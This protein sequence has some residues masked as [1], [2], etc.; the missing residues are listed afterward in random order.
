MS[1]QCSRQQSLVHYF[2][3]LVLSLSLLQTAL[4]SALPNNAAAVAAATPASNNANA[5]AA[6]ANAK[7]EASAVSGSAVANAQAVAASNSA[8]ALG[9]AAVPSMNFNGTYHIPGRGVSSN[10]TQ[11]EAVKKSL[12][13]HGLPADDIPLVRRA[14]NSSAGPAAETSTIGEYVVTLS[15]GNQS[16]DAV[17]D[18]GSY[19]T[20]IHTPPPLLFFS[21]PETNKHA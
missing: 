13:K 10:M 18:T 12:V 14:S 4:A 9:Q 21:T 5:N 15:I 16:L 17:F 7:A 20:Y 1:E 2:I 6:V 3:S 11:Q 19:S 8:V